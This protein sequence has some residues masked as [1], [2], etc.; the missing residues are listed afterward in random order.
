M[1]EALKL[2][3]GP[4]I[5]PN[6]I[7]PE[8]ALRR[9]QEAVDEAIEHLV[10]TP[11][12]EPAFMEGFNKMMRVLTGKPRR[13]RKS[14]LAEPMHSAIEPRDIIRLR[15]KPSTYR[16]RLLARGGCKCAFC[17]CKVTEKN[18]TMP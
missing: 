13:K 11:I 7:P 15:V 3:E 10:S 12:C 9:L 6:E 14:R 5:G 18:A 4:A 8:E 16:K 2:C 1:T 17:G